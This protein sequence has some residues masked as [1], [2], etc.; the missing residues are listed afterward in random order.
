MCVREL[1]RN[2]ASKKFTSMC[3]TCVLIDLGRSRRVGW[4]KGWDQERVRR[5]RVRFQRDQ[6]F[7]GRE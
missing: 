5:V 6:E 1:Q 3:V 7:V 2:R 4:K